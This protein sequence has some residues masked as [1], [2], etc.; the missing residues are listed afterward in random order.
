MTKNNDRIGACRG[1][2][3]RLGRRCGRAARSRLQR[4]GWAKEAKPQAW[5]S[6]GGVLILLGLIL[7][8]GGSFA[9]D[10]ALLIGIG[11]YR[12]EEANLPGVA[13]DLD[14]MREAARTLGFADSQIKVLADDEATLEGIRDAISDWLV[15][16]TT[17]GDRVLFY[18]S[19]HG[20]RIPDRDRDEND[21]S[22]E[23]LLPY[24]FVEIPAG[25]GEVR[26]DNVL[27]DDE[28]GRLLARIPAREVVALVDS[29]HSG[30]V[31]RSVGGVWSSKFYNYPGIPT[32]QQDSIADRVLATRSV[33][34]TDS[35]VLLAAAG[36]TEDAQTS[37]RGALF[38]QGVWKAVR[39]AEPREQ[40]TLEQLQRATESYIRQQVGNRKQLMHRPMLTGHADLRS[41]NLFLPP[42]RPRIAD[43]AADPVPAPARIELPET[44]RPEPVRPTPPRPAPVRPAPMPPA[45]AQAS[46]PAPEIASDLWSQLE[47]LVRD[48]GQPLEV[49][50][51]KA[52]YSVG[53]SLELS[54]TA[55]RDGYLHILNLGDGEDELIVLYPNLY[56]A[57]NHVRRGQTVRL[58]TLDTF[59]L[60]A[61]LPR[62]R[63]RQKNLV[64]AIQT[65]KPLFSASSDVG[66]TRTPVGARELFR[67][68]RHG[69]LTRSIS[70]QPSMKGYSAGQVVV[71]IGL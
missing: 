39:E 35:I 36:P 4:R 12:I 48:A 32:G 53:E 62:D 8:A 56:Q 52:V 59:T 61:R 16:P 57:D 25:G 31:T 15:A 65:S 71:T 20:S 13:E 55:P 27:V 45:P 37:Q 3:R 30:T 66:T 33:G 46:R 41:I 5:V 1:G 54:V 10:R 34:R 17:A 70:R 44:V 7:A 64:V 47:E 24:D 26:L 49:T 50:A 14:M 18:H 19:G 58:P 63:L 51:S 42:D 29:C 28:L 9:D 22:D 38:T 6:W 11:K 67:V 2:D 23:V 60:P 69:E 21:G 68:I 40:L 43:T